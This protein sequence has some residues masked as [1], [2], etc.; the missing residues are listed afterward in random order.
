M[1]GHFINMTN[2]TYTMVACGIVTVTGQVTAVQ[3]LQ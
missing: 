1:H 3:D 2:T